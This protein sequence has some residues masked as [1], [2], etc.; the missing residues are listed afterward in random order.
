MSDNRYSVNYNESVE[1]H[2]A[3]GVPQ[4]SSP[5]AAH[6]SESIWGSLPNIKKIVR[7]EIRIIYLQAA[8]VRSASRRTECS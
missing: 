2:T 3:S 5:S 4:S 6:R 1:I 7:L 8:R